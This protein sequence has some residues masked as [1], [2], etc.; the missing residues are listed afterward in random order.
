MEGVYVSMK[1]GVYRHGRGWYM[2][3][4]SR[5]IYSKGAIWD[6]WLCLLPV[7]EHRMRRPISYRRISF[8]LDRRAPS[9]AHAMNEYLSS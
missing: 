6:V 4:N 9:R 2:V 5:E 3:V 1:G 7:F 8:R